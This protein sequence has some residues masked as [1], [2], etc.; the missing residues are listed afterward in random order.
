MHHLIQAK[1][2]TNVGKREH[3]EDSYFINEASRIFIVADGM[4]GHD[5]GEVASRFT[6]KSLNEIIKCLKDCHL[7]EKTDDDSLVIP[8]GLEDNSLLQFA[9]FVTNK[10]I[11][12]FNERAVEESMKDMSPAEAELAAM[13]Q[14][15]KRMGTTLVSLFISDN[16]AFITSIGDSRA[17]KIKG[18]SITQVTNDHSVYAERQRNG[19][20]TA[21][22]IATKKGHNIITRSVGIKKSV[23]ADVLMLPINAPERYLLCSDGLSNMLDN[24]TI[25]TLGQIENLQ[26]ACD[27][28][29]NLARDRGG[30]DNITAVLVDI[31]HDPKSGVLLNL[32]EGE[33][34]FGHGD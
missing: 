30:K 34:T 10:Q 21:E 17:Y 12:E 14:T 32:G 33:S 16:N 29:V 9:V 8:A 13:T 1:A 24:E 19:L 3:N 22:E 15:R 4:G 31:K 5:K 20:L 25:L 2:S 26:A 11:F 6:A 7:A 28:L 18:D 23:K 27:R